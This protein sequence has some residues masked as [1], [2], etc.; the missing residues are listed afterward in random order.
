[1]NDLAIFLDGVTKHFGSFMRSVGSTS[2]YSVVKHSVSSGPMVQ[3]RL[4]LSAF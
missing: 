3:G 4:P 2:M 1:M